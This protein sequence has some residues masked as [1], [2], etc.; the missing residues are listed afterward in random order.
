M[1]LSEEFQAIASAQ[2][3]REKLL[4]FEDL[5]RELS[6]V[7][8]GRIPR[9]L[10]VEARDALI[11]A[12]GGT[13]AGTSLSAL[14]WMLLNDPDFAQAYEQA[15]DTLI[16]TEEIVQTALEKAIAKAGDT[17]RALDDVT[18]K[19]MR[20]PDGR[21]VFRDQKNI[22]RDEDGNTPDPILVDAL[23]WQGHEPS[24][25]FYRET[26]DADAAADAKVHAIRQDQT[27][28][29]EIREEMTDTN[30]PPTKQRVEELHDRTE[31]IRSEYQAAPE[32][33]AP[34]NAQNFS[35]TKPDFQ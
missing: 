6:G 26:F 34:E 11:E 14:D 19:A 28:L 15:M 1:G 4:S 10:S 22:V 30:N 33:V 8:V 35:I 9:F 12:R 13:K 20:L 29:G 32:P 7:E 21:A 31:K 18:N 3:E 2:Q 16:D 5:Q 24:Y 23:E 17:Q 27:E 25:E